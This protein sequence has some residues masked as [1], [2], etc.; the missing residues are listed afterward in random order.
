MT[1]P[2]HRLP[3][4]PRSGPPHSRP[5]ARGGLGL[6]WKSGILAA[7]LGVVIA[8]WSALAR[9]EQMPAAGAASRTPAAAVAQA[10]VQ[11][12]QLPAAQAVQ[13]QQTDMPARPVRPVFVR[14]ITRTRAS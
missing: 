4:S 7:G 6:A 2:T 11:L 14:P 8:G 13:V 12:S 5:A 10:P 1:E 3:H 9:A